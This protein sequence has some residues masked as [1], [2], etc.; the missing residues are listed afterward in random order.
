MIKVLLVDDHVLV[1]EGLLRLLKDYNDIEVVGEASEGQEALRII[2]DLQ[3][4]VVVMDLSMPGLDG[5]ETTK[6]IIE[7]GLKARV[8]RK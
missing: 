6:R 5:I 8:R 7:E 3:P 4:D 2:R 1:R